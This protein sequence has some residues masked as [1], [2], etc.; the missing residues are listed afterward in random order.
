MEVEQICSRLPKQLF[1]DIL[2][3]VVTE[4]TRLDISCVGSGNYSVSDPTC[5]DQ[6]WSCPDREWGINLGFSQ[7]ESHPL[8]TVVCETAHYLCHA[9]TVRM[10]E[11]GLDCGDLCFDQANTCLI[12]LMFSERF[13]TTLM[14]SSAKKNLM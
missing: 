1:K 6:N 11:K 4:L 3:K 7:K 12:K 2:L 13:V 14:A 5:C 10:G 9:V 8:N